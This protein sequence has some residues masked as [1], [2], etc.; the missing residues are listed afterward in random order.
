MVRGGWVTIG[1]GTRD[2]LS[3]RGPLGVGYVSPHSPPLRFVREPSGHTKTQACTRLACVSPVCA[4]SPGIVKYKKNV[5]CRL[6]RLCQ[7]TC[8]KIARK[9]P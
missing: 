9:P 8:M 1:H 6:D 7:E 3:A 2:P 5:I 4:G